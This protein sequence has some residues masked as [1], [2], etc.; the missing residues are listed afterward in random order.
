[1][2]MRNKYVIPDV[3]LIKVCPERFIAASITVHVT[4]NDAPEGTV[5]D[6]KGYQWGDIDCNLWKE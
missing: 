3:I 5:A 2:P 4:G 6:A 1:M